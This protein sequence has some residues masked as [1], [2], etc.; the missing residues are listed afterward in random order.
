MIALQL[1]AFVISTVGYICLA[2]KVALTVEEWTAGTGFSLGF[3][4]MTFFGLLALPIALL[5]EFNS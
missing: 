5:V 2:L 4:A 1:L 3:T